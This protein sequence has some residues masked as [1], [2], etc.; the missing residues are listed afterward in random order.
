MLSAGF[1]SGETRLAL[2][3]SLIN[4]D[5]KIR[6]EKAMKKAPG[7]SHNIFTGNRRRK[8]TTTGTKKVLVI[9]VTNGV[10]KP[11]QSEQKMYNDVF[12]DDNNLVSEVPV[13]MRYEMTQSS[14]LCQ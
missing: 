7:S 1:V 6:V 4:T 11:S 10:D 3:P 12:Q 8:L 14:I 9:L 5:G 2:A 13:A